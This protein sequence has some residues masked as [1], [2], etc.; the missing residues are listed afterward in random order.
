M[1]HM[2]AKIAII[3]I[4]WV[5]ILNDVVINK[6]VFSP[7]IWVPVISLL[8]YSGISMYFSSRKLSHGFARSI[9]TYE[10]L[11]VFMVAAYFILQRIDELFF[12]TPLPEYML[13]EIQSRYTIVNDILRM[14]WIGSL[15]ASLA[16][17]FYA[18]YETGRFSNGFGFKS[19]KDKKGE[20]GFIIFIA[21]IVI[22]GAVYD[23]VILFLAGR[24]S[25][26]QAILIEAVPIFLLGSYIIYN[27][28][29]SVKKFDGFPRKLLLSSGLFIFSLVSHFMLR[30]LDTQLLITS[31]DISEII[32]LYSTERIILSVALYGIL[33]S[34]LAAG[35]KMAKTS[36]EMGEKYGFQ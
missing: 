3:L 16:A 2:I 29:R 10:I 17:A 12:Q 32:S 19:K 8:I 13:L 23:S 20:Y 21:S 7:I 25:T 9:L 24:I 28:F 6:D 34:I 26:L 22:L 30:Y 14:L 31:L 27:V 33:I 1:G 15:L 18:V 11:F 36:F 35:A 4:F 5:I